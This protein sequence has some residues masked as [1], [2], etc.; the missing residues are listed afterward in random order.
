M[1][2]GGAEE[3]LCFSPTGEAASGSPV[4][5]SAPVLKDAEPKEKE[6]A[7]A[8][9]RMAEGG[10]FETALMEDAGEKENPAAPLM[11]GQEA[12]LG[13]SDGKEYCRGAAGGGPVGFK[14]E[15]AKEEVGTPLPATEDTA[16]VRTTA[17]AGAV[18]TLEGDDGVVLPG[19][20]RTRGRFKLLQNGRTMNANSY[21]KIGYHETEH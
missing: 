1:T 14:A 9:D 17:P 8:G 13:V 11:L 5:T 3:K 7:E 16:G 12:G 18:S 10:R 6:L 19:G 21:N 15:G 20:E 2:E 4:E